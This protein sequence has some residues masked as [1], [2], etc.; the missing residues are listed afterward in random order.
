MDLKFDK[1]KLDM[2]TER[3]LWEKHP[4][5]GCFWSDLNNP[6]GFRLTPE[7]CIGKVSL[8]LTIDKYLTGVI[9]IAHGGVAPCI[10]DGMMG[11][12]LIS[13]L[14]H[15]G[16]T[17]KSVITY[18][19][20]LHLGKT[21]HFEVVLHEG[22]EL[23]IDSIPLIG[24]VLSDEGGELVRLE[25]SFFLPNKKQASR[26]LQKDLDPITSKYFRE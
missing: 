24:R 14:G 5:F 10:L 22:R 4:E 1:L 11:W 13:H 21:Y 19:G 26:I 3:E 9:G 2:L 20:P 25:S 12:F 6:K 23:A 18:K 16:V 8:E 15:S 17:S 7:V